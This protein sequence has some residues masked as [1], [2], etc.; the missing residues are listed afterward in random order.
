MPP[1]RTFDNRSFYPFPIDYSS[2]SFAPLVRSDRQ[3]SHVKY[4]LRGNHAAIARFCHYLTT[5]ATIFTLEKAISRLTDQSRPCIRWVRYTRCRSTT[6]TLPHSNALSI[7][8]SPFYHH[9][10]QHMSTTGITTGPNLPTYV[11]DCHRDHSTYSGGS[12]PTRISRQHPHSHPHSK[13]HSRHR[14]SWYPYSPSFGHSDALRFPV[15]IHFQPLP[16]L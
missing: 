12:S 7:S 2:E 11:S 9:Y 14:T 10:Q 5:C 4:L 1:T 8:G 3:I 6:S 15:T 16:R 13:H